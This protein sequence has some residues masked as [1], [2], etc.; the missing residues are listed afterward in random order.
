MNKENVLADILAIGGSTSPETLESPGRQ[1]IEKIKNVKDILQST[2][3]EMTEFSKFAR[4]KNY[5]TP[6]IDDYYHT[7]AMYDATRGNPVRGAMAF[8]GGLIKETIDIPKYTKSNGLGYA[9]KE[10]A[11]DIYRNGRGILWSL[12][13][14]DVP[15]DENED[16]K[17]LQTPT[18]KAI[19]P[20][21]EILKNGKKTD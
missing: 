15:A 5:L 1:F 14:P 20:L 11:K 21:Y 2:Q 7:K 19:M 16:I 8:G 4:S 10:S 6:N 9:L 3:N 17:N 18:M 12:L 13:N